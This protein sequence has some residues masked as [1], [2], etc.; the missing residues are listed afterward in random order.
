MVEKKT[1]KDKSAD[2]RLLTVPLRREW[3]KAPLNRRA[4][5]SI[6]AIRAHLSRH[7]KVP[8]ADIRISAKLNDS[9]W[10]RGAGKPPARIRLKASLDASTGMLHA[11]LPDEE[12]P[13]AEKKKGEKPAKEEE[14]KKPGETTPTEAA[15][16]KEEST[17]I[18]EPEKPAEKPKAA[19]KEEVKPPVEEKPTEKPKLE[20]IV[21]IVLAM[22]C[23]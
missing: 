4:R 17:K 5:R 13:K 14:A 23:L 21:S 16:P 11:R 3:L 22:P 6:T 20:N 10:I 1:S 9:I 19:P 12:A 18:A 2:E 15:K 7:M 8:G